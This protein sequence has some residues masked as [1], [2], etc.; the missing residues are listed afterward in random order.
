MAHFRVA[1]ETQSRVMPWTTGSY[2]PAGYGVGQTRCR[3]LRCGER[4]LTS[5]PNIRRVNHGELLR[6][7]R[8]RVLLAQSA[9]LT[10]YRFFDQVADQ[11]RIPKRLI[12]PLPCSLDDRADRLGCLGREGIAS[13]AAIEMKICAS[14]LGV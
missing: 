8:R 10:Q 2:A 13:F 14:S 7:V 9:C 4:P 12:P 5:T 3:P 1:A 11:P 6:A